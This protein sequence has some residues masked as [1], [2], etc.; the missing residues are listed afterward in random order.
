[1]SLVSQFFYQLITIE[2]VNS[3]Y[4]YGINKAR[5]ITPVTVGSRIRLHAN[6]TGAEKQ[7]NGSVKIFLTCIIELENA[8]K[9]AY[10]ADLISLVV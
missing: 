9:P 5:F 3:F 6:F 1:M 2:N 10:V 7:P 8:D 4:N